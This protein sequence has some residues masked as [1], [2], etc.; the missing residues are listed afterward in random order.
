MVHAL[1]GA[2]W[3]PIPQHR[4]LQVFKVALVSLLCVIGLYDVLIRGNDT[5]QLN[6]ATAFK[7]AC[8]SCRESAWAR[9]HVGERACLSE[10]DRL[11]LL[12]RRCDANARSLLFTHAVSSISSSSSSPSS[13]SSLGTTTAPGDWVR[14]ENDRKMTEI[15]PLAVVRTARALH[16]PTLNPPPACHPANP[17]PLSP[18]R[19]PTNQPTMTVRSA[20]TL[21]GASLFSAGTRPLALGGL[22]SF[23]SVFIPTTLSLFVL[24]FPSDTA[25]FTSCA[26]RMRRTDLHFKF[27]FCRRAILRCWRLPT[28]STPTTAGT[29]ST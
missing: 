10:R 4:D 5:K 27:C 23:L 9:E 28:A 20:S 13:S 26:H 11:C 17:V 6:P 25:A 21:C 7:G 18:V 22:L 8:Q 16:P 14:L 3:G 29:C 15:R 24:V 12:N 1:G 2:G 19:H